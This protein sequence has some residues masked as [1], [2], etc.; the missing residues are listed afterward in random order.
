MLKRLGIACLAAII[1]FVIGAGA[2]L[3]LIPRISS[4]THD[5]NVEAAMT[6]FFFWGPIAAVIGGVAAFS[7]RPKALSRRLEPPNT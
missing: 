3:V 6:A 4:N 1:C 2:G 5:V 7:R